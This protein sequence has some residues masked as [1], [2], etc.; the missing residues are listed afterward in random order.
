MNTPYLSD[1][2]LSMQLFFSQLPPK[3]HR[4]LPQ[5]ATTKTKHT[6]TPARYVKTT[7][8]HATP[9]SQASYRLNH[10]SPPQICVWSPVHL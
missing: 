3:V 8:S 10:A 5:Q 6:S 7:F 1:F 9:S 4:P 2:H